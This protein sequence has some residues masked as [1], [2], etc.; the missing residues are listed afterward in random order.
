MSVELIHSEL[1]D[2]D[3]KRVIRMMAD[4]RAL[5]NELTRAQI[6]GVYQNIEIIRDILSLMLD[7]ADGK[8]K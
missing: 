7:R 5:H 6:R 2:A 8:T 3:C 1:S 4:A